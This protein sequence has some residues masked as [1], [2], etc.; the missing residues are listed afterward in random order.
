MGDARPCCSCSKR[1]SDPRRFSIHRLAHY[2]LDLAELLKTTRVVPVV[3]FLRRA[4]K[5]PQRLRLS[6]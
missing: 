1:E 2:C 5:V 4:D 3:I 6:S